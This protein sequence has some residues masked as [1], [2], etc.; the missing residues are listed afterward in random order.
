MLQARA[1]N[2]LYGESQ[3]LWGVDIEVAAASCT[4]LMGRNGVGKTSLLRGIVGHHAICGGKILW[5]GEDISGMPSFERAHFLE[6]K[7]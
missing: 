4:C 5:D 7:G 1:I 6:A 2:Q 3:I